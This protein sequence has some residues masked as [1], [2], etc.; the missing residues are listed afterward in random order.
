ISKRNLKVVILP[1]TASDE[2]LKKL[3]VP[4][5]LAS[6]FSDALF[7][8]KDNLKTGDIV[9][10]SPGAAY[11]SKYLNGKKVGEISEEIL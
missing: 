2:L 8:I 6:D 4:F 10:V 9:L 7:K 3:T 1:G 11:F 5:T